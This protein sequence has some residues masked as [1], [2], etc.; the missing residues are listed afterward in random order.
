MLVKMTITNRVTIKAGQAIDV[1]EEE[2]SRL[3]ALGYATA[4]K[5]GKAEAEL[6]A[7]K[8]PRKKAPRK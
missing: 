7:P 1:S 6:A 4:V 2:A 8:P 5:E 3:I